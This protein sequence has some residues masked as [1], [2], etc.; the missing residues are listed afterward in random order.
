[1]NVVHAVITIIISFAAGFA[2]AWILGFKEDDTPDSVEKAEEKTDTAYPEQKPR[3][4]ARTKHW[5]PPSP[6]APL[7]SLK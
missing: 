4:A 3:R 2:A 5:L 1:M 7:F 6:D